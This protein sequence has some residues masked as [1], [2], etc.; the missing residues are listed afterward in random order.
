MKPCRFSGELNHEDRTT[1]LDPNDVTVLLTV[2]RSYFLTT[3][4]VRRVQK[5]MWIN[6][7][8]LKI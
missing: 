8:V 6:D 3:N 4:S 5:G 2:N 1:I 7:E